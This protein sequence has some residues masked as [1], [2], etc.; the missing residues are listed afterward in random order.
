MIEE[1]VRRQDD[2]EEGMDSR[3][4]PNLEETSEVVE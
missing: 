1:G 2:A 4:S 3:T